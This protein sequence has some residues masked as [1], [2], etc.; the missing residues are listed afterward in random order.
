MVTDTESGLDWS[1]YAKSWID[2]LD[3][4]VGARAKRDPAGPFRAL[5][6]ALDR[7]LAEG[8]APAVAAFLLPELAS[9][10][11]PG[12]TITHPSWSPDASGKDAELALPA[13]VLDPLRTALAAAMASGDD[14]HRAEVLARQRRVLVTVART[15]GER[16]RTRTHGFARLQVTPD[17]VAFVRDV[18]RADPFLARQSIPLATLRKVFSDDVERDVDA[19]LLRGTLEERVRR[20]VAKGTGAFLD[21]LRT[22][23]AAA[24]PALTG[25]LA[26]PD[27]AAGAAWALERIGRPAAL[28]AAPAMVAALRRGG[29]A[30]TA[31][32]RALAVLGCTDEL[33]LLARDPQHRPVVMRALP[34]AGAAGYAVVASLLADAEPEVASLIELSF[35]AQSYRRG[36]QGDD[37]D[38]VVRHAA[39]HHAVI[40]ADVARRLAKAPAPKRRRAASTLRRMLDDTSPEVRALAARSLSDI[41]PRA[42]EQPT[43]PVASTRDPGSTTPARCRRAFLEFL[44]ARGH[45]LPDLLPEAGI[46]T[47]LEHFRTVRVSGC[48]TETGADGLVY[49]VE[50][51]AWGQGEWLELHVQRVLSPDSGDA[52]G[53]LVIVVLGFELAMTPALRG[54]AAETHRL[55]DPRDVDRFREVIRQSLPFREVGRTPAANV[56]LADD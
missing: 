38:A 42:R 1:R 18:D 35:A 33:G 53:D 28:A 31:T 47:M 52:C 11:E 2:A 45:R 46:E 25:L 13:R 19:A 4:A 51:P 7:P 3:R 30:A 43:H 49:M 36:L 44:R 41:G 9:G 50:T 12:S 8:D 5:V 21:E 39:S 14:A 34:H 15:L 54:R 16:G 10:Q 37:V 56:W 20:E 32:A 55:D 17:F 40:R 6:L 23:G 27:R 24:V 26:E 22:L 48:S 29:E